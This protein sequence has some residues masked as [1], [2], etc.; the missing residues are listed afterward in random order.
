MSKSTFK[1]RNLILNRR[2]FKKN[3]K[4]SILK[5]FIILAISIFAFLEGYIIA[6]PYTNKP[7]KSDVA[8]V[9]GCKVDSVFLNNRVEKAYD[10]YRDGL[11]EKIIVTGGKGSGYNI[12]EGEWQ[13]NK[14]IYLGV[15]KED[16]ILE[17]K[18]KNTYENIAFAKELMNEN[19]LT[20]AII[21]SNSFHLRRA[22]ILA[23]NQQ[24]PVSLAGVCDTRYMNH[25][26]YGY[27]REVP[28][29][30]KTVI[31]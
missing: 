26:I 9:L 5:K 19:N 14:L 29:I 31:F 1:E 15:R 3:R 2:N 21:V 7:V 11:V 24:I 22:Q 6:A 12:S 13:R 28:A 17:N 8:I 16:I 20:S 23:K 18:S 4:F 27:L 25:E 10:L 30:I